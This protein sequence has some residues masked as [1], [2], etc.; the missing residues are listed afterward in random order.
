MKPKLALSIALLALT[1]FCHS[2]VLASDEL[3]LCGTVESVT[4][5]TGKVSIDVKSASCNGLREF[6]LPTLNKGESFQVGTR[7]C[8]YI[9]SSECKD[10]HI[11]TITKTERN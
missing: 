7:K 10:G 3:Y 1:V 6:K 8:F 5:Q 2:S 4:A 11:Y 9:N